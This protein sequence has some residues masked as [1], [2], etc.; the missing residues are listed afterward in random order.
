MGRLLAL[1]MTLAALL[2]P[3]AAPAGNAATAKDDLVIGITQYPSTLHPNIDSM[4]AKS[5]VLGMTQRPFTRA[6]M[7][8]RS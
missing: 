4:V 6:G 7:M 2:G 1:T 8:M 3:L 5:Y